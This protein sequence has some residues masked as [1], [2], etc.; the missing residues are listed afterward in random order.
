MPSPRSNQIFRMEERRRRISLESEQPRSNRQFP[1]SMEDQRRGNK[2]VYRSPIQY[3]G[4]RSSISNR[5]R[6]STEATSALDAA[7]RNW[8]T[9]NSVTGLASTYWSHLEIIE[10]HNTCPIDEPLFVIL[11]GPEGLNVLRSEHIRWRENWP[12]NTIILAFSLR[13]KWLTECTNLFPNNVKDHWVLIKLS[14]LADHFT[15]DNGSELME[16]V[17]EQMD[18]G[19]D[20][21]EHQGKASGRNPRGSSR[22]Q[23]TSVRSEF[24]LRPTLGNFNSTRVISQQDVV[25]QEKKDRRG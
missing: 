24:L 14:E 21:R 20:M 16:W 12:Q 22:R 10:A 6:T 3:I 18:N 7:T 8:K 9:D 13:G 4:S 1:L 11:H 2:V 5:R 15:N 25:C 19:A 23:T 17:G